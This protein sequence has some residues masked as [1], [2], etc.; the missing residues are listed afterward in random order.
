MTDRSFTQQCP[1]CLEDLFN[2]DG[3]AEEEVAEIMCNH[4]IHSDCLASTGNALNADGKR[5]GFGGFGP[6]SGCPLCET[7]VSCWT[8]SKDIEYFKAFWTPLIEDVLLDIGPGPDGSPVPGDAL[9]TKL[10]ASPKLNDRQKDLVKRPNQDDFIDDDESGFCKALTSAG[11]VEYNVDQVMFAS[12]LMTRGI[13]Q[14]D[15]EDDTLWHWKWGMRHPKL[16]KCAKCG[17]RPQSLKVCMDCKDSC[18]APLYCNKDCQR[19]DWPRHKRTCKTFKI[20]KKGGTRDE[21]LEKLEELH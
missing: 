12:F 1:V 4:L 20:M 10:K 2:E 6:R 14:Y 13:W 7:P 21:L 8:S 11:S 18:Q 16:S 5:F 9:R 19:A 17:A 15:K 3:I